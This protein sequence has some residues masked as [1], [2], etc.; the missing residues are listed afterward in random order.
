MNVA[1]DEIAH[2]F[3]ISS[4]FDLICNL[5]I[6][7]DAACTTFPRSGHR[8]YLV[9]DFRI[10]RRPS[11][12]D[13]AFLRQRRCVNTREAPAH[14]PHSFQGGEHIVRTLTGGDTM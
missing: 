2:N 6:I 4:L 1:L 5:T 8:R 14:A 10:R 7:H 12:S 11:A 13:D 9:T 3:I